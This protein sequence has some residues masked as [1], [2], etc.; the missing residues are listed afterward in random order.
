MKSF[1]SSLI[2][3]VSC[4]AFLLAA[5]SSV[6]AYSQQV[7]ADDDALVASNEIAVSLPDSPGSTL[8]SS[9]S[10]PS[11]VNASSEAMEAPLPPGTTV[12]P[13][14]HNVI[15]A[16]ETGA[17]LGFGDKLAL[18]FVSRVSLGSFAGTLLGAGYEQ[19]DNSR[20]HY[21]TDRGAFGER[22]GASELT[23][24]S[25]AV[26][27]YAGVCRSVPSRPAL[28]RDGRWAQLC[29][30]DGL[31]CKPRRR[32]GWAGSACD[33]ELVEPCGKRKLFCTCQCVLS[34]A[35]PGLRQVCEQLC[36]VAGDT[37]RRVC[38]G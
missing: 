19:V 5:L 4:V 17:P 9:S 14:Y 8:A 7:I 11:E 32:G 38:A 31:R 24:T 3:R 10:M 30:S 12:A 21:G 33:G 37:G 18:A 23:G 28:L 20:P 36:I 16:N 34:A 27:S 26:F 22:L 13:K 29:A 1:S 6:S 2:L 25:R 35:G 15:K